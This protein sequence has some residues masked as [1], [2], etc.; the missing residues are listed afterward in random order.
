MLKNDLYIG[1][2]SGTSVDGVD[3]VLVSFTDDKPDLIAS[4]FEE[5]S[6]ELRERILTLCEGTTFE[7]HTLGETD[8]AV[9]KWFATA[10]NN[11]L[12]SAK[13]K[14][15]NIRAIG[16]HGQTIWHQPTGDNP[17]SQ[18]IGNPNII[19]QLTGITTVADFRQRDMAVGGQGA[20]LAPLLH[21]Q[22]FQSRSVD[23]AVINIG[24]IANVTLLPTNGACLAF[25]SG[26]GNMLMDYWIGKHQKKRF[27]KN[28][29]WASTG[30]GNKELLARFLNDSYF[31]LCPPKST[32]RE[33][34]SGPWL[35]RKLEEFGQPI[36]PV[37]V[38][39]TLIDCTVESIVNAVSGLFSPEE[40]YVCG[41]G[42]HNEVLM[43]KLKSAM[44]YAKVFTTS[45]LRIDPDWVEAI[46]FAWMAKQTI[47]GNKVDTSAF[48]GASEP[49]VL[50]G[51]FSL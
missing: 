47:E 39:A 6:T 29:E 45:Q 3:C 34:F 35:E 4:Y 40:I 43:S 31:E 10:V 32:G 23:R 24:G 51:V 1:L 16:S 15:A 27:D 30:S 14:A 20:P 49:V 28:G 41:G 2:I 9:G 26:P 17:F 21:R 7:L 46:S 44:P 42:T 25:D 8:V 50:G 11:L 12:A 36:E 37:D 33:L 22:V 18:Q 48:T 13:V 5:S 38:Q 19:A